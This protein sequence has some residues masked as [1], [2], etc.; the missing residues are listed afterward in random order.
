M[1]IHRLEIRIKL[2]QTLSVISINKKHTK[3]N[4]PTI[5]PEESRD[6]GDKELFMSKNHNKI[7]NNDNIALYIKINNYLLNIK[8]L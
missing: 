8:F 2:T 6:K 3:R 5:I 1:Q 4:Q 7:N